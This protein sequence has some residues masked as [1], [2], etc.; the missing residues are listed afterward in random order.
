M[1]EDLLGLY[2]E[3]IYMENG[4]IAGRGRLEELLEASSGFRSFYTLNKEELAG[5]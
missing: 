4:E 5:A 3:I 1:N 2:D